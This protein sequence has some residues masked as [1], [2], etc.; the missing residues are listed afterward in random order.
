MINLSHLA[1]QA[2]E[3]DTPGFEG[4]WHTIE[5]QPDF[6]V[7]Q[8]FIIGVALSQKGKL[9]HYRV[10]EEAPRLACFYDKRFS[11]DVWRWMRG[12]LTTELLQ[13]KGNVVKNYISSSPQISL[14]VGQYASGSSAESTLARAFDRVVTVVRKDR[15][16]RHQGVAQV[17]LRQRIGRAL[18]MAWTTRYETIAQPEGGMAIN[19]NGTVHLFDVSFDDAV[20]ASSVV[21]GCNAGLEISRLNVLTAWN[22]LMALA[23]IRQRDQIGMAVLQPTTDQLP[24]ETVKTWQTWWNDFTYKLRESSQ[25]LLAEDTDP[26]GLAL[27]ISHWYPQP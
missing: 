1:A 23:R 7:P 13:Y 21:S 20:T 27:Q 11:V 17:E 5:L 26:E 22:D 2:D 14:G 4:Q 3:S 16:P 8:R 19:D 9:T 18:K 12:E 6:T 25:V 24:A 10:A 15:R